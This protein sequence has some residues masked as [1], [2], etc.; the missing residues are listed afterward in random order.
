MQRQFSVFALHGLTFKNARPVF[1]ARMCAILK[2]TGKG[3]RRHG[4]FAV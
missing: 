3:G 1:F 2:K 4:R